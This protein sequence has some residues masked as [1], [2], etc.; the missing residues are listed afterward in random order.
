MLPSKTLDQIQRTAVEAADVTVTPI[1]GDA[2]NVIVAKGDQYEFHELPAPDRRHQVDTLDDLMQAADRWKAQVCW[3]G[4]P[5]IVLELDD[6]DRRDVVTM[7][8]KLHDQF[9]A[10]VGL[11][12]AGTAMKQAAILRW[13]KITMVDAIE[14]AT[15]VGSLRTIRFKHSA[16]GSSKIEHG[17]ESFGRDVENAVHGVEDIPEGFVVYVPKYANIFPDSRLQIRMSLEIDTSAETFRIG[18]LPGEIDRINREMQERLGRDL[19]ERLGEGV[20]ILCGSR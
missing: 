6:V 5:A 15:L 7:P 3:H 17:D 10:V 16:A 13:L 4:E 12:L 19:K 18:P 1:P 14:D 9:S 8:L 20:T 2:H 11:G